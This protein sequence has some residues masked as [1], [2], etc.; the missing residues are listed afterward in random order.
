MGARRFPFGLAMLISVCHFFIYM[1]VFAISFGIA[2]GGVAAPWPMEII[3]ETLGVPL[4]YVKPTWFNALRRHVDDGVIL[5]A[6]AFLNSLLWGTVLAWLVCWVRSVRMPSNNRL[7][8]T[9]RSSGEG[10]GGV[11]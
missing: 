10:K 5:A 1:A 4:M 3:G 11:E 7:E 6:L 8:R 9:G 2:D